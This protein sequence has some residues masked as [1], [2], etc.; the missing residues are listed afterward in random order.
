MRNA[1]FENELRKLSIGISD[2]LIGLPISSILLSVGKGYGNAR[3]RIET[4]P[5]ELRDAVNTLRSEAFRLH[6][7]FSPALAAHCL[8][9]PWP[10]AWLHVGRP[11]LGSETGVKLNHDQD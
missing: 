5:I 9:A 10:N 8:V 7:R 3:V 2:L 6:A 1:L 11:C 4:W